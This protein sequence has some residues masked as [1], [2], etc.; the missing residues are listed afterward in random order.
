[1]RVLYFLAASPHPDVTLALMGQARNTLRPFEQYVSRAIRIARDR[2]V[3]YKLNWEPVRN[4]RIL[5]L[6]ALDTQILIPKPEPA[7]V[8]E[9]WP[10]DRSPDLNQPI[11]VVNRAA[12]VKVERRV[13]DNGKPRLYLA[14]DVY[15]DDEIWWCGVK[16]QLVREPEPEPPRQLRSATRDLK[17]L[18]VKNADDSRNW[19]VVV[20]GI[21]TQGP[22]WVD[23][24]RE[25]SVTFLPPFTGIEW[26]YDPKTGKRFEATGHILRIE[27]TPDSGVLVGDNNVRYEWRERS[28]EGRG[29]LWIQLLPPEENGSEEDFIDPRAAFCEEEV[30]ETWTQPKHSPDSVI[31]VRRVDRDNYQLLLERLP[32]PGQPIYLPVDVRRLELQQR[33][34]RQ[35]HESPLPHHQGLLRLCEDPSRVRWTRSY[36]EEPSQWYWLRDAERSGTE[37]QRNFVRQALG[38][39]DFAFLEGPPGS[40]KTTAICELI[41]Q[42][43]RKGQRVLLSASTNVAI[44]NVLERMLRS[45]S[46]LDAVRI[47]SIDR[48]DDRVAAAQ[49]DHRVDSLLAQ[50]RDLPHLQSFTE[51]E[52]REMAER[53]V[54]MS[55]N[56]T[57]GTTV[58]ITRH[59]LFREKGSDVRRREQPI[60]RMPYWDVLIVDE[61]SKTTIQEFIVPALM[62]KRWIVVGDVRQLPPYVDRSDVVANLR[63]L[64]EETED[65]K[66]REVLP[67]D[68]QRALL[69]TFRLSRPEINQP[70]VR[71]LVVEPA[72]VLDA[73][74]R[75]I[76]KRPDRVEA[77]R[78]VASRSPSP[79]IIPTVTVDEVRQD[80]ARALSLCAACWVLVQGDLLRQVVDYL[81]GNML[82]V[83]D[84]TRGQNAIDEFSRFLFRQQ[85]WVARKVLPRPV[86]ERGTTLESFGSVIEYEKDWL[87]RHDWAGE[88]AWRLIRIHELRRNQDQ[89]ER[90]RRRQDVERL[91]PAEPDLRSKVAEAVDEVE[92]IGLPGLLEVI[93]DGIGKDR[94]KRRSALTVGFKA[95]CVRQELTKE[96]DQK[97]AKA[98]EDRFTCLTFQHRM[99][100]AIAAFPREVIYRGEALNDANT[101]A[102]RDKSLEWDFMTEIPSRRVWWNVDGREYRGVNEAEI[103]QM[104]LI[105]QQFLTW[106]RR[107][108]RPNRNLPDFWEVACL[109]FYLKQ[110]QAIS[111]MLQDLT[112]H[113]SKTRF[114]II[115]E[116]RPLA[117]TVCG[118]VDRFQGREADLV[119]LSMRNTGRVGFLDSVNRLN[120]AVTRARQQLIVLGKA[121][122]FSQC[123]V[124]EL[125]VL[126]RDTPRYSGQQK[127]RVTQ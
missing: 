69:L 64:T 72:G 61:A 102:L 43:V 13:F 55:A 32:T 78:I 81:P 65:N 107:K 115:D 73:L 4:L 35:L 121:S 40:G 112:G 109:C 114:T 19:C 41:D 29:G 88:V 105:V 16:C 118:V 126:V 62:A 48:V 71:W 63:S 106:A 100:P 52:L 14:S 85:A 104:R 101:I 8:I 46:P 7:W 22:V 28:K 66:I 50:W 51:L 111:E 127:Q 21:V 86:R 119:L 27:E 74:E 67:A 37:E 77:V 34:L 3:R 82:S 24:I 20:E 84:L 91:L 18:S 25:D 53:T 125:E 97:L 103:E 31:R 68:Y 12:L 70:Q 96:Q 124:P 90:S 36:P 75:E 9:N 45:N 33:A 89:S 44:D 98:F 11:M 87:S 113:R 59:P 42:L 47:G 92:E 94:S 116:G 39:Q 6:S 23:G 93:Q 108:G 99:H 30:S 38:T 76:A 26:L 5:S 110:E 120:V 2:Q 1:V 58:G 79:S 56:L 10:A 57:C 83:R 49:I 80:D 122:Y 60:T 117:E 17:I 54:V 95:G 15:P 123:G